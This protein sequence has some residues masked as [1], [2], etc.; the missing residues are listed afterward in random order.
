MVLGRNGMKK[1]TK[2]KAEVLSD[3]AYNLTADIS[4]KNKQK[5]PQIYDDQ[6]A[7]YF[8]QYCKDVGL[9]NIKTK[10]QAV[11]ILNK[12]FVKGVQGT[13]IPLVKKNR[14]LNKSYMVFQNVCASCRV[15]M[16]QKY[17]EVN[18]YEMEKSKNKRAREEY[19]KFEQ[20]AEQTTSTFEQYKVDT[21]AALNAKT[22][23][24]LINQSMAMPVIW[25]GVG[26]IGVGVLYSFWMALNEDDDLIGSLAVLG[27]GAGAIAI[28][29]FAPEH[30][31]SEKEFAQKN[32]LDQ[33]FQQYGFK[34]RHEGYDY[35]NDY[36]SLMPQSEKQALID[37]VV[38]NQELTT[39]QAYGFSSV[40]QAV[41]AANA[42][43]STKNL[44]LNDAL[45][46][47]SNQYSK[48]QD[49]ISQKYGLT[50]Y[51]GA[52]NYLNAH[53]ILKGETNSEIPR[54][55]RAGWS[56]YD[57]DDPNAKFLAEEL[58]KL[59]Q[60]QSTAITSI[61]SQTWPQSVSDYG[62][63]N[64]MMYELKS[65]EIVKQV[66][67]DRM[68]SSEDY[69]YGVD[70]LAN[71]VYS[72]LVDKIGVD[73]ANKYSQIPT[74]SNTLASDVASAKVENSFSIIDA[75]DSSMLWLAGA[76]VVAGTTLRSIPGIKTL[77][78]NSKKKKLIK[79]IAQQEEQ[80]EQDSKILNK[81]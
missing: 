27:I 30:Q 24:D 7:E 62:E 18:Y 29:Y 12:D 50:D 28:G 71:G 5:L 20:W 35:L 60:Y 54:A 76:G 32:Q 14:S 21:K 16:R 42:S 41:D 69:G 25:I 9:E 17:G 72:D 3:F 63:L 13:L 43:A 77:A 51:Q 26:A 2:S 23:N 80:L 44:T 67:Y 39:A 4:K 38:A 61:K 66:C 53:K 37:A 73:N 47:Q 74:N 15:Q 64:Q 52:I 40:Q 81:K 6:F 49:V 31:I 1:T 75:F 57:Y 56:V 79:K 8:L 55:V 68:L 59:D 78:T 19:A 36:I 70:N 46:I 65:A 48:A 11:E 34:D 33:F 10:K 58:S 45:L 22:P